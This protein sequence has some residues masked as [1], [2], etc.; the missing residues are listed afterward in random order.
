VA[1]ALANAAG[2]LYDQS[3]NYGSSF[4]LCALLNVLGLGFVIALAVNQRNAS[5]PD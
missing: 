3:G 2:W 1:P 5:P 4:L